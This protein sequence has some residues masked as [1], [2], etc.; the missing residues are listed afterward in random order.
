VDEKIKKAFDSA[1]YMSV[2]ASQKKILKEEYYQSLL[3]YQNGGVFSVTKDLINFSKTLIDLNNIT[4]VIL[5]DDN[6][7][8]ILIKDLHAFLSEILSVYAFATNGYYNKFSKLKTS[9]TVEK[10]IDL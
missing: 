10:L 8:P 9:R 1:N 6:D 5:V 3:Y 2:L 7:S 4:D